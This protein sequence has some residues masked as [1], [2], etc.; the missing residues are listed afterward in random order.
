MNIEA[1]RVI[2]RDSISSDL[3][4]RTTLTISPSSR[5]QARY[6]CTLATHLTV[7]DLSIDD[8]FWTH[9]L[10]R[11]SACSSCSLSRPNTLARSS[12]PVPRPASPPSALNGHSRLL[13]GDSVLRPQSSA[14][15]LINSNKTGGSETR[16]ERLRTA[17]WQPSHPLLDAMSKYCSAS[18]TAGCQEPPQEME[19]DTEKRL[20]ALSSGFSRSLCIVCRRRHTSWTAVHFALTL[21]IQISV[22]PER[23]HCA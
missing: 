23:P 4:Y 18:A 2:T 16:H 5:I 3:K 19:R 8:R 14:A 13:R 1:S 21:E 6:L 17:D 22:S 15:D 9:R 11:G 12:K 7:G 10:S 20:C